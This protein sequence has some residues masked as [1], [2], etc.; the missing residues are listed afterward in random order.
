M[1]TVQLAIVGSRI[2][3]ELYYPLFKGIV[4]RFINDRYPV[5]II[6]IVT[7][8]EPNG[9]DSLA[10]RYAK[11]NNYE[12]IVFKARWDLY[13]KSAGPRRNTD[14]VNLADE[15][16]AIPSKSSI[17]TKDSMRKMQAVNKP[18]FV[19]SWDT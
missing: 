1:E 18:L 7:G 11:E 5:K 17:G 14:I 9:I 19:S 6:V 12:C 3:G 8:D 2:Y 10:A 4:D 13:G 15:M 16:L